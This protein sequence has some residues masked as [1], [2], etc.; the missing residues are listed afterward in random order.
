MTFHMPSLSKSRKAEFFI[1]S[2]FAIVSIIYFMGR[3]MEPYTIIDTSSVALMEEPFIFNNVVDKTEQ[4]IFI[5]KDPDDLKF[6][7]EEYMQFVDS[8]ASRK[9]LKIT[10]D[11]SRLTIGNPT[12]GSILIQMT[13]PRMTMNRTLLVSKSFQ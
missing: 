3:W 2:A 13:S 4:T 5:S 8:Y 12:T 6:N 9:N 11:T 7:L 1:L 10:F